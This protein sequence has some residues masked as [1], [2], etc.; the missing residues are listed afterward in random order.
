MPSHQTSP[1][2]VLAQLVKI[3]FSRPS[4]SRSGSSSRRAGRDAEEARLGLI[5]HRRP[6]S[7]NFIQAM[8]SPTVST[9]QPSSVGISIARLVLP[10]RD[11]NAPV[12]YLTRPRARSA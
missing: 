1:S 11:G 3:V 10:Q 6:S 5:A 9:V 7:P 4:P 8:S 2:S 12:T